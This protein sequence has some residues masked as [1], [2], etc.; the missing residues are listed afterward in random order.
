MYQSHGLVTYVADRRGSTVL[1][2]SSIAFVYNSSMYS[3]YRAQRLGRR[4]LNNV[5]VPNWLVVRPCS[6]SPRTTTAC[7]SSGN[8]AKL[9]LMVAVARALPEVQVGPGERFCLAAADR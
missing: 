7:L 6:F 9:G 1:L 5:P 2:P 8:H 3:W 4:A